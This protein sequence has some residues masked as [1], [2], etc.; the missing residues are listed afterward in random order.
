MLAIPQIIKSE[1]RKM[2]ILSDG[3]PCFAP[4]TAKEIAEDKY[5][6]VIDNIDFY[7]WLAYG[8]LSFKVKTDSIYSR[9][10]AVLHQQM[11]LNQDA[12]ILDL[13]C[14]VGRTL[15]ELSET[16]PN[17]QFIGVDY[18]LN[19]LRRAKQI[20]LENNELQIDL[21]SS[22]LPPFK[23]IGKQL[24]NV[25]LMQADACALPFK[26]NSMDVLI[27]TFLIDR[28]KDVR[29]ALE[30]MIYCLKPGGFFLLTSPL[31]FQTTENWKYGQPIILIQLLKELGIEHISFEDNITHTEVLDSRGNQKIWNTLMVWGRKK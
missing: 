21:S 22:G 30:Q 8:E 25:H 2:Y 18:S 11:E 17:A 1:V 29:L 16:F 3:I 15:Y 26:S 20:L 7:T 23:L 6:S 19:M 10:N 14:G 27:N 12:V 31:N 5:E 4:R 9:I 28:V 13:G 24:A